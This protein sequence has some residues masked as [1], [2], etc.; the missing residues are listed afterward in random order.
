MYDGSDTSATQIAAITGDLRPN[1]TV[2]VT[3][4]NQMLIT[5]E[6]DDSIS[7]KGFRATY[8]ETTGEAHAC[9]AHAFLA[10]YL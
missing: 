5:F 6:T 10:P 9:L 7:E 4:G 2:F 8:L 1:I 3:T